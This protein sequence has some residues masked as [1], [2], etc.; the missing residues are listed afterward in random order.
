MIIDKVHLSAGLLA[1][2]V[3]SAS[4][5]VCQV[6]SEKVMGS[7]GALSFTINQ[8]E[9]YIVLTKMEA[10]GLE[11]AYEMVRRGGTWSQPKALS[12]INN[13]GGGASVGGVFL[14]DDERHLYFHAR[15]SPAAS[16]DI[17][18][19]DLLNGSWTT[20][21]R[22]A[23]LSHDGDDTYPTVLP[24]DQMAFLLRHQ[25][26]GDGKQ[27]RKEGD[28]QTIYCGTR[29]KDGKWGKVQPINPAISYGFVQDVRFGRDGQTMWYSV[30]DDKKAPSQPLFSRRSPSD[31]WLLP[32]PI[33]TDKDDI[34]SPQLTDKHLFYIK[35]SSG[36]SRAG[37]IMMAAVP[38]EKY[39]PR[40]TVTEH[41]VV[42][43]STTGRPLQARIDVLNPITNGVVGKYVARPD[44]GMFHL[45]N[46]DNNNYQVEVRADG[47]SYGPYQLY[48][49]GHGK[50]LMPD[51]VTL[52]DTISL[53]V[54]LFDSE[55]FRPIEGKLIAVRQSDKAIY[56]GRLDRP[57]WF[58]LRLPMGSDYNIIATAK[59]F[60]ENKFLFKLEGDIIF[61]HYERELSLVAQRRQ[62]NVRVHE[63][64]SGATVASEVM[65]TNKTREEV[66]LKHTGE[67]SIRLR[68]GDRYEV[69]VLPPK[70]Y[71]FKIVDFDLLKDPST[72]LDIEVL[73]L[74]PGASLLLNNVLFETASAF[75]MPESCAELDRLVKLIKDNPELVVE[76]AAHTDNVGNAKYN[77]ALSDQRAA[78]VLEYLVNNGVSPS[79]TR[80][81]GYGF[82][83]PVADN[84]TEAGRALNRRVEFC[85][86]GVE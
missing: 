14:T 10:N 27:E 57:G 16:Y 70:G 23:E 32:E 56:R 46:P 13:V 53:G 55:I 71:G 25:V 59:N 44:D 18:R 28:R 86:V 65:F 29:Q 58:E 40:P 15:T 52:F 85:V 21:E 7:E 60:D 43:S 6:A 61:G 34:F 77:Y 68:E 5:A 39:K 9:D 3:L 63:M 76:I 82:D 80:S 45:V 75:L 33:F 35:A 8:N 51:K 17:Y 81:K 31:S 41:G 66:L 73:G 19:S 83:R 20:P 12:V 47:H 72:S 48:Y 67:S 74:R 78:S 30:R 36:K 38:A 64:Q 24:G 62:V 49:D 11:R 2:A 22:E 79:R 84:A 1:V 50:S 54:S 42:V 26:L 37:T 69:Q 4:P